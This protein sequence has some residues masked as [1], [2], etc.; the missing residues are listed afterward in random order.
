MASRSKVGLHIL[1]HVQ[2][3][4]DELMDLVQLETPIIEHGSLVQRVVHRLSVLAPRWPVW[5]EP[6][7]ELPSHPNHRSVPSITHSFITSSSQGD[8]RNLRAV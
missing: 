1:G 5:D 6:H 2:D 3:I 7:V 4:L 8:H